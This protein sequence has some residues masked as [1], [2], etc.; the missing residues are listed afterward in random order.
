LQS[1]KNQRLAMEPPEKG[2]RILKIASPPVN[3]QTQI[4][5]ST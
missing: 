2:R 3:T 1:I 5:S 4:I